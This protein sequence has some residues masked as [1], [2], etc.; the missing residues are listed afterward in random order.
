MFPQ[1]LRFRARSTR[2]LTW[3]ILSLT[4]IPHLLGIPISFF[5][6][7]EIFEHHFSDLPP[8]VDSFGVTLFNAAKKKQSLGHI[9][10]HFSKLVLGKSV[11]EWY[12][13]IGI[14]AVSESVECLLCYRYNLSPTPQTTGLFGG[15]TES[16]LAP[17]PQMASI[18]SVRVKAR[19]TNDLIMPVDEYARLKR[20]CANLILILTVFTYPNY[21]YDIWW[22]V[23]YQQLSV[24][25][26]FIFSF[27]LRQAQ[28][29][30]VLIICQFVIDGK[31]Q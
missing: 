10:I 14:M 19:F 21:I 20:V 4:Q 2:Y 17:N 13:V 8:D 7:Y 6:C 11:D 27:I 26:R 30:F 24:S 1:A 25:N 29:K 12:C 28:A 9:V 3:L 5:W 16:F 22:G 31:N 15:M 18:G 23:P